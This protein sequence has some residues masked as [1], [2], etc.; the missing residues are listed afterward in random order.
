MADAHFPYCMLTG[1]FA[2]AVEPTKLP[3]SGHPLANVALNFRWSAFAVCGVGPR[4][5]R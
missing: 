3:L 4:Q 1:H 2:E 5:G